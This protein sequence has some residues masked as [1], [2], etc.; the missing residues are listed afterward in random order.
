MKTINILNGDATNYV[1]KQTEMIGDVL[2][3]RE[4]LS[5]GPVS[6][7]DLWSKRVAWICDNFG[8][9]PDQY[10]QKVILEEQKLKHL[11]GYNEIILWFE[12]DLVCQINLIY[13]LSELYKAGDQT[14]SIY[15]VCPEK[16]I[17]MPNFRGLGELSPQQLTDLLPTKVKLKQADLNLATCAWALYVENNPVAISNF[18]Q[19]DFGNLSLLKKALQAHLL[20]FPDPTTQLNYIEEVLLAIINAGIHTKSAIYEVFWAK[21]PIFGMSDLQLDLVLKSLK[22]KGLVLI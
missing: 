6:T 22:E 12:Y 7:T 5:E 16:I 19:E 21:E 14:L 15:L 17:G 18:L 8:E 9:L 20:R 11:S 2:I 13:I 4:I 1:F 3:W 10:A